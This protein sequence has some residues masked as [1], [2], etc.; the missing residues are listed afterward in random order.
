MKTVAATLTRHNEMSRGTCLRKPYLSNVNKY[1]ITPSP[2]ASSASKQTPSCK[3]D[4][5]DTMSSQNRYYTPYP[6][7]ID[8]TASPPRSKAAP[9]GR[10][11]DDSDNDEDFL[12]H[13]HSGP[14]R[15]S[16][17]QQRGYY[18]PNYQSQLQ[19]S[20]QRPQLDEPGSFDFDAPSFGAS[21]LKSKSSKTSG[22]PLTTPKKSNMGGSSFKS[23]IKPGTGAFGRYEPEASGS[24]FD[25]AGYKDGWPTWVSKPDEIVA[26]ASSSTESD[27]PKA[28]KIEGEVEEEEFNIA[29][30]QYT[31]QDF[32][33]S[34][35]DPEEQM[36]DLLSGAVGEGED[37]GTED[38]DGIVEGFA[39]G[40][41]LMPHQIRGVRWMRERESGRKR[42]GILADVS[43]H[44]LGTGL[45]Y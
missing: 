29:D 32:E 16:S 5:A 7:L 14:L 9:K 10:P 23:Y 13:P 37:G 3:Q 22:L 30:V 17:Q 11:A 33:K 38:G 43:K 41:R 12:F 21:V 27:E 25:H 40:M 19:P 34:H 6:G 36:R 35:G 18:Q 28:R 20:S 24:P 2:V 26:K 15:P 42:G 39:E 45:M 31:A 44:C 4:A 8:L 1:K